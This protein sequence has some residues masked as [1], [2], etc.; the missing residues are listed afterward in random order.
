[1]CADPGNSDLMKRVRR[2]LDDGVEI[3]PRLRLEIERWLAPFEAGRV[4][5]MRSA[6]EI[7]RVAS[8]LANAPESVI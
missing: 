7:N 5:G 8:A 3:S 4:S 2:A 6:M 1:M